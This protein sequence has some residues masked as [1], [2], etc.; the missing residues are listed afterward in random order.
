MKENQGKILNSP[1]EEAFKSKKVPQKFK[2]EEVNENKRRLKIKFM[3]QD[4][5]LFLEFWR[6]NK[7]IELITKAN[8]DYVR[9]GTSFYPDDSSTIEW[10]LQYHAKTLY[11]RTSD[12]KTASHV[13]D[14]LVLFGIAKYGYARNPY[15]QRKN[16]AIK[17]LQ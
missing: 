13:C 14:L 12:K 3:K 8:G 2:I 10:K 11:D 15:S 1:R 9:L 16:Q 6:F 5:S 17:K 4:T 7:V